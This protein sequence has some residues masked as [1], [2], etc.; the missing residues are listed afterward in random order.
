MGSVEFY[1]GEGEVYLPLPTGE[2]D[3]G[4]MKIAIEGDGESWIKAYTLRRAIYK[5]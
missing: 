1:I 2:F 5:H 3:R 4:Q